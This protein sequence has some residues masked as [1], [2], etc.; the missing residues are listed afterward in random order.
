MSLA[1]PI[2]VANEHPSSA[3][4]EAIRAGDLDELS[5]VLNENP[6]VRRRLT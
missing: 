1:V 5:Q 4:I 6:G 3:A 2:I